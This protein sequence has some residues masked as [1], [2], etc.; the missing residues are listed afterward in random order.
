[1]VYTYF[2]NPGEMGFSVGVVPFLELNKSGRQRFVTRI[3]FGLAY[4]NRPY[5][6]VSNP[7]NYYIGAHVTNLTMFSALWKKPVSNKGTLVGGFTFIHCSNGHTALPNVGLNFLAATVGFVPGKP[8]ATPASRV[9]KARGDQKLSYAL[10]AGLGKHEFGVTTKAVGGPSYPSYHV[11]GWVSKPYGSIHLWQLGIT[12]AYYTS[13]YDYLSTQNLNAENR[14]L[15]ACTGLL[16]AGHE[17]VFGKFSLSTQLGLYVWNRFF[18]DQMKRDGEWNG[19]E[20]L[21][22]IN[23]NRLG[24]LYYP[25]K[26]QNSLNNVKGQLMLGAFLKANLA[27]ADLVEWSIGYVF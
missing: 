27:Q 17:F 15:M 19:T 23:S 18:I 10:K 6:A 12:G 14:R 11:S 2:N 4:F 8:A 26:K 24:I 9:V 7:N 22:A 5:D 21:K 13:F 3:G 16:F 1:M 25:F 20:R